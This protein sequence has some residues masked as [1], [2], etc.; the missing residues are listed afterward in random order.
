MREPGVEPG[1]LGE[2]AVD[3]EASRPVCFTEYW[4]KPDRTAEKIRDGWLLT[5]DLGTRDED[6]YYAFHSRKDDVIISAGYKIGPEEVEE[7]LARHE[8]VVDAGVVGVPDQVRGAVPKA[9]VVLVD[10]V[11]QSQDLATELQQFVKDHLADYQYPRSIEF[12]DELPTTATGKVQR[13]VLEQRHA[14]DAGR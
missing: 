5:E 9:F 6:G 4:N 11:E 12:I 7:C 1:E 10:G 2:I 8:A 13:Y 3:Y 14:P